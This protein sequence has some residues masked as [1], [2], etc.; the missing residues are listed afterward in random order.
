[1]SNIVTHAKKCS[2]WWYDFC[3]STWTCYGCDNKI[4][5]ENT[6]DVEIENEP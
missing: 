1:M 6:K 3:L 2:I 4:K 5:I